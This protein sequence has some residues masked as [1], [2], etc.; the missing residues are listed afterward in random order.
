MMPWR[1]VVRLSDD[2]LGWPRGDGEF[3]L[4]RAHAKHI[5]P[6]SVLLPALDLT[7]RSTETLD[8]FHEKGTDSHECE[9][10]AKGSLDRFANRRVCAQATLCELLNGNLL[11]TA[12]DPGESGHCQIARHPVPPHYRAKSGPACVSGGVMKLDANTPDEPDQCAVGVASDLRRRVA[13]WEP[14]KF[15]ADASPTYDAAY[16]LLILERLYGRAR[17]LAIPL[18][19]FGRVLTGGRELVLCSGYSGIGESAITNDSPKPLVSSFRNQQA[20]RR[21]LAGASLGILSRFW[22]PV[23]LLSFSGRPTGR[24]SAHSLEF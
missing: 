9:N 5:E 15:I 4:Y 16:Y 24:R 13:E 1:I 12:S 7:R 22:F 8:A 2:F 18:M 14:Q 6:P 17:E 21:F 20:Q 19:A 3:T 10:W 11:F 23:L